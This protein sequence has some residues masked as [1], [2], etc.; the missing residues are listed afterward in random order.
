M[1]SKDFLKKKLEAGFSAQLYGKVLDNVKEICGSYQYAVFYILVA[2]ILYLRLDYRLIALVLLILNILFT[3]LGDL[4]IRPGVRDFIAVNLPALVKEAGF[5]TSS[6]IDEDA[7][8]KYR[9][10]YW[11]LFSSL[12][13]AFLEP[14]LLFYWFGRW[15]DM[16][17]K[18]WLIDLLLYGSWIVAGILFIVFIFSFRLYISYLMTPLLFI[19]WRV[20]S[21]NRPDMILLLILAS[22]VLSI[23]AML[24]YFYLDSARVARSMRKKFKNYNAKIDLAEKFSGHMQ[25]PHPHDGEFVQTSFETDTS[26][27]K[28]EK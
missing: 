10:T 5:E 9:F 14:C 2:L 13:R 27:D 22:I 17:F 16:E 19:L 24:R 15:S 18:I 25:S 4:F 3:V 1:L 23:N 21:I 8:P 28:E 11:R 12:F 7:K 26:N 6:E 20:L